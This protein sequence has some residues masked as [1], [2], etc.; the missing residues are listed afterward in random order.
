METLVIEPKTK[1]DA[2]LLQSFSK[3]IGAQVIDA[4]EWL[5]DMAL[6]RLIEEGLK[7]PEFVS[8]DE[9]M[10]FLEE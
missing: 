2:R 8:R 10:K 4:N 7:D 1:A 6:G 9:V 3:R 5:E